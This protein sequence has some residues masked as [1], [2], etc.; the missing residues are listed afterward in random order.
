MRGAAVAL[1][2]V[3]GMACS[4]GAANGAPAAS[5]AFE[6][7]FDGHHTRAL[8]HEG[9]FTSTASFCAS[10]TAADITVD[11]STDTAMRTFSCNGSD[12]FTARLGPLPAE[13]GGRG[14]WQ[15][16]EGRGRLADLRGKGTWTSVRVSGSSEDLASITFRSS[17]SGVVGFDVSPPTIALPRARAQKLRKPKRTYVVQLV[18]ALTDAPG[19]PVSYEV[20]VIDTRTALEVTKFGQ[21]STGQASLTV[22]VRP[23]AKTRTLRVKVLATDAVGNTAQFS[24]AIRIR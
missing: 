5:S 24:K 7:V 17:W 9:S 1:L 21:T 19:D 23:T 15:I 12:Q 18:V 8:L 22:R 16:V 2:L 13:H 6:L 11:G 4:G 20:T 14:S 3:V 10:G